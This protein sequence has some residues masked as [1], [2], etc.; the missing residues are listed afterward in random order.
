MHVRDLATLFSIAAIWG[1]SYIFIR[2][3][4]P[5]VG[6]WGMVGGRM[7]ISAVVM[8]AALLMAGLPWGD[9]KLLRHYVVAAFFSSFFAQYLIASAALTLNAGTLAILN[10]TAAMFSS[11]ILFLFYGEA[12]APK[13][14]AGLILGMVG[15]A[16][17]VGFAPLPFTWPVL[18]AFAGALGAACSY[19]FSSIYASRNMGNRPALELAFT[20]SLFACLLSLPFA[21]P[22]TVSAAAQGAW[23]PKVLLALAALAVVC[24]ALANGLFYSLMKRT[25]PTVSL[26]VTYLIPAFSLVWAWLFLGETIAPLQFAGFVVIVVAL[27]L[28]TGSPRG[29]ARH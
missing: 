26:S 6:P 1:A 2:I 21:V 19:A 13:R 28:V 5:A 9:K 15:V 23:S 27:L 4:V 11:M 24:T 16:L 3:I 10:T 8:Y 25:G 22:A 17:V 29:P 12:L 7:L 18:L 20:Q 14:V